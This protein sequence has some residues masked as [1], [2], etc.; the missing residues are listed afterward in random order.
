MK[1]LYVIRFL[2]FHLYRD[3]IVRAIFSTIRQKRNRWNI[4]L[5]NLYHTHIHIHTHV[6]TNDIKL[7]ILNE[8]F[9]EELDTKHHRSFHRGKC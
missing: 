5:F 7:N 2:Y 3:R 9:A 6:D 4:N 1:Y 8:I